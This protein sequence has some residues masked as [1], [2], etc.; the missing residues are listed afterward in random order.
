VET[1]KKDRHGNNLFPKPNRNPDLTLP[2]GEGKRWVSLWLEENLFQLEPGL[3][4][5]DGLNFCHDHVRAS[6]TEYYSVIDYLN[7]TI[8]NRENTPMRASMAKAFLDKLTILMEK[9]LLDDTS[10]HE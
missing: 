8:S 1:L 7:Y 10:L 6:N 3:F 2:N 4:D 9:E 5:D